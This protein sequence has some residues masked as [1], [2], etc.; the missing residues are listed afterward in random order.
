MDG[1]FQSMCG[2]L[3]K[4]SLIRIP[5]NTFLLKIFYI[6]FGLKKMLMVYKK[7]SIKPINKLLENQCKYN[8]K[9]QC[10]VRSL[11]KVIKETFN[12]IT[13]YLQIKT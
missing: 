2:T 8:Q 3:E 6:D 12:K 10:H 5:K 7:T 4:Q 9:R 11:L 1:S 13:L